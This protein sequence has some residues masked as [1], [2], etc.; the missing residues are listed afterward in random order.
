MSIARSVQLHLLLFLP[1]SHW[2]IFSTKDFIRLSFT[3]SL[4]AILFLWYTAVFSRVDKELKLMSL[5]KLV[6]TVSIHFIRALIEL[7]E[8]MLPK[9]SILAF[10]SRRKRCQSTSNPVLMLYWT[11]ARNGSRKSRRGCSPCCG[12][13]GSDGGISC[14]LINSTMTSFLRKTL[15]PSLWAPS[16]W[17]DLYCA[18]EKADL[19]FK[20]AGP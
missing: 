5:W 20:M 7:S 17:S 15:C 3:F 10:I 13:V 14:I 2:F 16:T 11:E 19:E 6:L 18:A 12:G 9:T 1:I 4:V 8:N